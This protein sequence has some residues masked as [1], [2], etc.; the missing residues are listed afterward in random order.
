MLTEKQNKILNDAASALC[1]EY[2]L[3]QQIWRDKLVNLAQRAAN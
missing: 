2:C 1:L 3:S